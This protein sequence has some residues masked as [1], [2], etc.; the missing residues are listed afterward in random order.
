M[1][2]FTTPEFIAAYAEQ[3][4]SPFQCLS[5]SQQAVLSSALFLGVSSIPTHPG[6]HENDLRTGG[7][8]KHLN[9]FIIELVNLVVRSR[10]SP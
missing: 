10:F 7:E 8:V 6:Y 2:V 9:D 3:G 1:N 5:P 4:G